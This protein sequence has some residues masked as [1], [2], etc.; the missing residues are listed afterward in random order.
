MA[1]FSGITD[2]VKGFLF[3]PKGARLLAGER[4]LWKGI[5]APLLIN[6]LGFSAALYWTFSYMKGLAENLIEQQG[7]F[8][9]ALGFLSKILALGLSV[10]VAV[11]AF[12]VIAALLAGP[13]NDWLGAATLRIL[14]QA[15]LH[16]NLSLAQNLTVTLRAMRES[17]KEVG[18]FLTISVVLF[19][20]G[21][22]YFK[23]L[24]FPIS[25]LIFMVP[26]PATI[27][28]TIA[29]PLQLLAANVSTVII[30]TIG[31]PVFRDGNIIQLAGIT[32][33]VAEAC[34]GIRSLITILT[35]ATIYSYF[36]EKRRW[37]QLIL[38]FSSLP[39]AIVTN[40]ARVTLTAILAHYFGASAADGF[41]HTFEGWFMFVVAFGILLLLGYVIRKVFP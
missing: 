3:L 10:G 11:V 40:S 4:S 33:E 17:L 38:V 32:L 15:P 22:S 8:W 1:I 39:I 21:C 13:F 23:T 6:V 28:N 37:K 24:L 7:W 12:L 41:Y 27:F 9:T 29:F 18:Y 31:I 34:S 30:S 26:L 2:F 14:G 16:T 35:L 20:L 19:L 36:M 5:V 25:F